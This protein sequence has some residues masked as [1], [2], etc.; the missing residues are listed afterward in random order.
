MSREDVAPGGMPVDAIRLQP[1]FQNLGV[2]PPPATPASGTSHAFAETVAID[3]DTPH[4]GV[5]TGIVI[6]QGAFGVYAAGLIQVE[7]AFDGTTPIISVAFDQASLFTTLWMQQDATS[8]SG[9]DAYGTGVD[10]PPAN[11][12]QFYVRTGPVHL[13]VALSDGVGG[14]TGA[15]HGAGTVLVSWFAP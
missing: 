6:P 7:T 10:E 1:G 8:T 13:W 9:K 15:S 11:G 2:R 3:K 5:D 12:P 14:A 4:A